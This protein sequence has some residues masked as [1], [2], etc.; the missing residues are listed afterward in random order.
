MILFLATTML[1]SIQLH[2]LHAIK[3]LKDEKKA[4]I[5]RIIYRIVAEELSTTGRANY[6]QPCNNFMKEFT[7]CY[8][9]SATIL[10]VI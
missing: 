2:F 4:I 1:D 9:E 6:I 3:A 8:D 5:M 7:S 10:K